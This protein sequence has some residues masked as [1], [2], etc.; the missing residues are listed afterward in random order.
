M[1]NFNIVSLITGFVLFLIIAIIS[2]YFVIDLSLKLNKLKKFKS[3]IY[4]KNKVLI[5][6]FILNFLFLNLLIIIANIITFILSIIYIN[7]YNFI[8]LIFTI[9]YVSYILYILCLIL[10]LYKYNESLYIIIYEDNL[11]TINNVIKK[12]EILNIDNDLKRKKLF[13]THFDD[14]AKTTIKFK[15]DYK[16]KDFLN[17]FIIL[18]KN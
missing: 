15:Y 12:K 13:L 14:G 1:P 10:L 16:L 2:F 6:L 3:T 9:F 5:L 8:P 18:E 17:N 11:I 7:I 4:Y